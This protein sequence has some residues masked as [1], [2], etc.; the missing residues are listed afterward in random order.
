M[1]TFDQSCQVTFF[2][3]VVYIGILHADYVNKKKIILNEIII[4][5]FA[6]IEFASFS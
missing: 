4:N 3:F 1:T 6:H 2:N 5:I